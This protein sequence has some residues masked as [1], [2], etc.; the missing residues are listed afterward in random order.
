[1]QG[2][3]VLLGVSGG[4]GAYKAAV[5]ARGLVAAGA[6]VDVVLTRGAREF[7]GA[8]T[9]EGITGRRVRTEVWEDVADGTHVDLGRAADVLVVYPATAHTL[10]RLAQGLADDLLTTAALAHRGPVVLAPAM[11]TEM[12]DHAATVTNV[13][14]LRSRGA[15]LVGPEDGPLM[16]G[17][18]G[19]GRLAD[20]EDVL[21]AVRA[22]LAGAG[23]LAGRRLLITAGGTREPL[24]P[25]RFLGN[26]S[27]GRMGFA[28]AAAARARGAEVLLVAAPSALAT[29]VGVERLDVTTARELDDAVT[30]HAGDR[31]AVLMAAAVADF[32]PAVAHDA[33]LR[34]GDGPPAFELVANPDVLAGVVAR[35]GGGARPVVVGFAAET[36]DLAA[37]ARRKLDAKGVDLLVANDVAVPGIG[38]DSDEN[39]VLIL[40]RAG[41]ERA[42]ARAPKAVVADAVLDALVP[43]LPARSGEHPGTVAGLG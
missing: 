42:V 20:P 18:A 7:V 43:L 38:F 22:A 6:T 39:A 24:D 36:G 23:D 25:V 3:R 15:V 14:T 4:I 41:G 35:R 27:S 28:L 26:R 31:D 29:P 37:S 30:A 34:R 1:M 13:A 17:D 16:G 10:A 8:A 32:R 33:K 40:D 2:R 5:L 12:W 21:V 11:H 9:F 19:P